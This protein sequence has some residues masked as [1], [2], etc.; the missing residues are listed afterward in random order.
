MA[1]WRLLKSRGNTTASQELEENIY[2]GSALGADRSDNTRE[3]C[4]DKLSVYL[5]C[6]HVRLAQRLWSHFVL[7]RL[8]GASKDTLRNSIDGCELV[9]FTLSVY[10]RHNGAPCMLR[11][12]QEDW[13]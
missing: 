6:F 5:L 1:L 11:N 10:G 4:L 12:F 8:F 2:G 7:R 3:G 9:Y 13:N